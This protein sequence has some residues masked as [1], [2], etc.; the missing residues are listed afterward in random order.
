MKRAR[1]SEEQIIGILKAA[2][3][4]G[5]IR[6]VCIEH[7]ITEQTSYRWRNKYGGLEVSE[8]RKMKELERENSELKKM[9]AELSLDNRMLK[10]LNGATS[11]SRAPG[12][13]IRRKRAA[14][15]QGDRGCPQHEA[16][17]VRPIQAQRARFQDPCVVEHVPALWLPEDF[18]RLRKEGCRVDREQCGRFGDERA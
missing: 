3:A 16:S 1:F 11:R 14:R 5:N 8:A 18:H 2:E 4:A 6:A 7:N 12:A 9:V 10:D 13:R 17:S 15:L